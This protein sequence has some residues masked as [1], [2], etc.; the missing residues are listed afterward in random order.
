MKP[1]INQGAPV[2]KVAFINRIVISAKLPEYEMV[3]TFVI[4]K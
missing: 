4:A 3:P 2:N 1:T